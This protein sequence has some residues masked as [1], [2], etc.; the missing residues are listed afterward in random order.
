[1]PTYLPTSPRHARQGGSV[2]V[3][4][5]LL[6]TALVVVLGVVQ[7][8]YMYYAKRDLQRTA[9]LAAM[10][11]VNTLTYGNAS[12]CVKGQIVGKNSID[13]QLTLYKDQQQPLPV[14]GHWDAQNHFTLS[15][16]PLNAAQVTLSVKTLQLLPFTGERF[17]S[18]TAIAA[19]SSALAAAFS[20]GSQLLCG[21]LIGQVTGVDLCLLNSDGILNAKITP[22]SLLQ[23]LGIDLDLGL[24]TPTEVAAIPKI[25]IA[26]LITASAFLVGESSATVFSNLLIK[27]KADIGRLE[28]PLFETKNSP[29]IFALATLGNGKFGHAADVQV[30]IFEIIGTAL[31]IG[32]K[33]HAIDAG[34]N[35]I[36]G[37]VSSKI[38]II[39]PPSYAS[40][41]ATPIITMAYNSQIRIELETTSLGSVL[42][43]PLLPLKI[44][45]DLVNGEGTLE[46]I[47]CE[48]NPRTV[49][50][51]VKS[52]IGKICIGS[53]NASGT[54]CDPMVALLGLVTVKA[55]ADLLPASNL[56]IFDIEKG[57][58]RESQINDLQIGSTLSR[59]LGNLEVKLIGS[60][61]GL[62]TKLVSAIL[63]PALKDI[64]NNLGGFLSGP[65]LKSLLGLNIGQTKI[66]VSDIKCDTAQLA[67]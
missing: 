10:V 51:R 46:K 57:S 23:Q 20:V 2:L 5:A 52:S 67:H 50:I 32:T 45:A 30:S 61:F 48:K 31:A 16:G 28:I 54:S 56:I 9:D 39:S 3:Q 21:T 42:G 15:G 65:I 37:L 4:F 36:G 49:D 25:K 14:C 17:V 59:L 58:T 47:S 22:G 8:G 53:L 12:T 55:E 6:I 66:S 34:V 24:L 1:M 38:R 64:L 33:D 11:T 35:L 26:D 40:G 13:A 41:P 62:V 44:S 29:G 19:K 27:L 18:A 7:I 63:E 43:L 60:D